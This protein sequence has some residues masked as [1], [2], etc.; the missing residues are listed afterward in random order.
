MVYR[1]RRKGNGVDKSR[2][3][4]CLAYMRNENISL[5][6]A[7]KHFQLSEATVR[8]HHKA[9]LLN[10]TVS[11]RGHLSSLPHHIEIEL[12]MVARTAAKNGFG[13]DKK[14]LQNLVG[15]FV[16]D[17]KDNDDDVSQYLRRNCMFTNGRP[18]GDWVTNFM[19]R[20]HLSLKTPA[21]LERSRVD[22]A[23]DPFVIYHFYSVLE[24][25]VAQLGIGTNPSAF[26]N[27]DETSFL[28]DPK[29]GKIIGEIGVETKRITAGSGRTSFTAM[30]CACADGSVLPPLI[31]FEAKHFYDQWK[32]DK[33]LPG[34]TYAR[35][36]K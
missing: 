16:K 3:E 15:D 32:G 35:S 31:I 25:T 18:S 27:L 12:A 13:C 7:A 8:R 24:N 29:G 17:N 21:T 9:Y 6:S 1:Y 10:K 28:L 22:A 4:A 26:Y 5:N 34:T 19:R 14:E 30:V 33:A 23:S 20:H 2:I 11:S 36:G